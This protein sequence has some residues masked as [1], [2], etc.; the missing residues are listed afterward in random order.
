MVSWQAKFAAVGRKI[1]S[2]P[3][4]TPINGASGRFM[5]MKKIQMKIKKSIHE[6]SHGASWFRLRVGVPWIHRYTMQQQPA[7]N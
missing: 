4:K 5:A 1:A 3:Q 7:K 6:A 2:F